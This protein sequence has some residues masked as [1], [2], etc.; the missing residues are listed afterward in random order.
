[1]GG[2]VPV[3]LDLFGYPVATVAGYPRHSLPF[4]SVREVRQDGDDDIESARIAQSSEDQCGISPAMAILVAKPMLQAR[5]H[6]F[7]SARNDLLCYFY[8][9]PE[10]GFVV[11]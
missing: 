4:R 9:L 11:E 2:V 10:H 3:A 1:M 6:G 5:E 7:V 8:L